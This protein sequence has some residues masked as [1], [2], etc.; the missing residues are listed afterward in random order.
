MNT[1][2]NFPPDESINQTNYYWFQNS[3]NEQDIQ[4]VESF[5]SKYEFVDGLTVADNE[6]VAQ[7]EIRKSKIKWLPFVVGES[8][9][10]YNK[11]IELMRE[12]N[13]IWDFNIHSCLDSIQYTEYL[14]GGGH[15]DW[16][17][18]IGPYPINHRKISCVVQLSDP[19]DYEGGDLQIWVGGQEPM[20][21]PRG[22]G[23]VVFFPS[24]C[25]HRVTPVTKG[26]RRSL[27]LWLGG[28]SYK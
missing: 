6:L 28:D 4:D 23:N 19:E 11:I 24:F 20:T 25:M 22:K 26:I 3:F 21:I 8:G 15:Y 12:A 13:G 7:D 2:L 9:W 1:V 14:E 10:M 18:D 17:M 27:V 16:H 5:A